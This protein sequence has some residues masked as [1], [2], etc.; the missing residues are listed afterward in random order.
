MDATSLKTFRALGDINR[1]VSQANSLDEA[2]KGSLKV[3]QESLGAEL[4][5]VWYYD[6][7]GDKR[8]HP[9]FWT[10][11]ND[12]TSIS[13]AVGEG[14][15]GKAYQS[16]QAVRSL[17]FETSPDPV[18]QGD[19]AGIEVRS[20]V[21]AP[22]SSVHDD[23]GVIQVV[24]KVGGGRLSD[25]D[26]DV[27][28]IMSMVV[29]QAV[30]DNEGRF[31]AWQH[32]PTIME[33]RGI[34]REFQNGDTISKV[35]RGV[36]LDVYEGEFLVLLGES[37][38]GKSTLL[39]IIGGMDRATA[40]SFR[41]LHQDLSAADQATLTE[42]RRHNIGFIFQSY[43]LMPNLTAYQNLA[44]IADLV[45]DPMPIIEAL[46]SVGLASR[47]KSYPSRLSGGQQQRISIARALVKRP[48][49]ILA[50]EPTAALDYATSIEVLSTLEEVIA[51]GTTLVMVTHNEEIARMANRVVRLRGGQLHEVTVNRHPVHATDLVW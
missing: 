21:C 29:A 20:A 37:G 43:N 31:E 38:C 48:R 33:L 13:H 17:W 45:D 36:N 1:T 34:T 50:D 6:E 19:F 32:G 41:Y 28:E 3:V 42:Y 22:F 30:S 27:I 23:Y 7:Q 11:P 47:A 12:L 51:Q 25:E 10:G 40:G 5:V 49:V 8:L 44:L 26:A 46:E 9:E 2:I 35:L 18:T 15:V 24:N 4:V 39:N 14:A 16:Q